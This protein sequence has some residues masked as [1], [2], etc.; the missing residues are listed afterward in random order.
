MVNYF[1]PYYQITKINNVTT[2]NYLNIS[3]IYY[4]INE[5]YDSRHKVTFF[6]ELYF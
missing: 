5:S 3:I 1:Y 4:F 6:L 2:N